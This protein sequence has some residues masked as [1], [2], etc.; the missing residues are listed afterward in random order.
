[1]KACRFCAAAQAMR[2]RDGLAY[3]CPNHGERGV[4][5]LPLQLEVGLQHVGHTLSKEER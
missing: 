4:A 1:M 5:P 3:R 2:I